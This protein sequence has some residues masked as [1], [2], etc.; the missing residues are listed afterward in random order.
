MDF[1]D[2]FEADYT[3]DMPGGKLDEFIRA[4]N[5]ARFERLVPLAVEGKIYD[6]HKYLICT[7]Y[8]GIIP[9]LLLGV[10][11]NGA[12]SKQVKVKELETGKTHNYQTAG[13]KSTWILLYHDTPVDLL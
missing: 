5:I 9:V 12:G 4:E 10:Y 8:D 11:S 3:G 2:T 6:N 1:E 13:H 7:P